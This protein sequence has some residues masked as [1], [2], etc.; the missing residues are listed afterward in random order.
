M[1]EQFG[2]NR[3]QALEAAKNTGAAALETAG[4]VG[5]SEA[6]APTLRL[7][8]HEWGPNAITALEE[9][10]KAH[11]IVARIIGHALADTGTLAA[12]KWLKLFGSGK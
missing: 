11:P 6:A 10:A 7:I 1:G 8:A 4:G 2:D 12:A 9:A 5:F 3:A